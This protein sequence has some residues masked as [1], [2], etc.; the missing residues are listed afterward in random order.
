MTHAAIVAIALFTAAPVQVAPRDE[1][2]RVAP[3]DAAILVIVQNARDHVRSLSESP[4]G[5]WFPTTAI[6]Q[7]LLNSL[8]L[9]QFRESGATI[10]SELGT[11]P[12]AILDDVLGDAV[13]FAYSPAPADRPTD[14]RA[15]ILVRPGQPESLAKLMDRINQVQ[16]RGG[17]L[18]AVARKEHAG[19]VYFER[20]KP[21]GTAEFYCFRGNVFAFSSSETDIKAFID[22]D[23][24]APT[25]NAIATRMTTLGVA[26]SPAVLLINPRPL[27][28][29][30]RAKVATAK[31]D[32]KRF[33]ERFAEVWAGLEAAAVYVN[34]DADLEVGLALRFHAEKLPA[35]AKRWLTGVRTTRP[36]ELLIPSDAL[37]GFAGHVRVVELIDL[38]ASVAPVEM[39]KPGFD[40]WIARTLGPVIGK[41]KLPVVL[42]ALGPNW[43]AWVEP[44]VKDAFLPTLVAA[45]E[46]SGADRAK[47]EKALIDAVGFGFRMVAVAYN[48][49]HPDQ[50]EVV[51]EKDQKTGAVIVSLV[52]DKGFP[53]GFRPSFAVQHGYLVLATSP[54]AITRFTAP[55]PGAKPNDY[56]TLARLSGTA[57]REYL[58]THG[59]K[60]ATFLAGFGVGEEKQLAK[61][62]ATVATAMELLDAADVTIRGDDSSLKISVR[63]KTAKPLKK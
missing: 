38:V 18:K 61:Q 46:I 26:D 45:I 58:M 37:F 6:G 9:N 59:R 30:V 47:S 12:R 29:E 20:Q 48:V 42:N 62:I 51:E 1:L 2:L 40:D 7:Q 31:P 50:I 25:R 55:R 3:P 52:N 13:A 16:T 36:A 49:D 57:C 41:D 63:I 32:E 21:D 43:A 14:E 34:L 39:G 8:E 28:A 33:L 17:E 11:T 23:K 24:T 22:R 60:L 53:A 44:P 10:L 15:V 35:D 4:F 5:Q 27:D 54:E 56:A 19:A